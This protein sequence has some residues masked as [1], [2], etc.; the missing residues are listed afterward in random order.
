MQIK[1][2]L[3]L[4][5]RLPCTYLYCAVGLLPCHIFPSLPQIYGILCLCAGTN[6]VP[7]YPARWG[8]RLRR[9][10]AIVI[11]NINPKLC[12][13]IH[14]QKIFCRLL[15]PMSSYWSPPAPVRHARDGCPSRVFSGFFFALGAPNM[16]GAAAAAAG[17]CVHPHAPGFLVSAF[18]RVGFS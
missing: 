18:A 7:Y 16:I 2:H 4:R 8:N 13:P 14:H 1:L 6:C 12:L 15:I 10:P 17:F 5:L 9:F 11:L 3:G